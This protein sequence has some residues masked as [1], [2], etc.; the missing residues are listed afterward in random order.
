MVEESEKPSAYHRLMRILFYPL[1]RKL[2]IWKTLR[3]NFH[4]FPLKMAI[5]LPVFIHWGV[6]LKS[7]KGCIDL[8]FPA[9]RPGS[10][11]I[12]KASYGF[13]TRYHPTIWEQLG[14]TVIFG[15]GTRIGKGTFI[16]VG[17][18]GLLRFGN[19]VKMGGNDNI[20]CKKSIF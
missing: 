17:R 2:S 6:R 4:Y 3:F 18:F 8:N 9:I 5:R 14:G 7:M 16:S 19:Q 1:Y 10:V 11:R 15:N 13:Q 20:I 12:G